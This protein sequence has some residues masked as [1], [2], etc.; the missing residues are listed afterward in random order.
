MATYAETNDCRRRIIL[1]HFGDVGE[2][3]ADD[4]CDNC[5]AKK[6]SPG[7]SQ[8]NGRLSSEER[9][10]LVI[11]DCIRRLKNKIGR[12]KL[13]KILSGSQARDILEF[14]YDRNIYYGRF[15]GVRQ[16]E[17]EAML[18][19]LVKKGYIKTIGGR[20]PVLTLTPKGETA[21][22]T[23]EKIGLELPAAGN[24]SMRNKKKPGSTLEFTAEL[25]ARG[26]NSEQIAS[27]RNLAISTINYHLSQLIESG[28]IAIEQVV[29]D[30]IRE[31]VEDA[32]REIGSD[33]RLSAIKAILPEEISY[34]EIHFV[35]A[36]LRYHSNTTDINSSDIVE[37][38]LSKSHPRELK[39]SWQHGWSLGFH[40]AFSG[41]SWARS[42]IGEM[43]YRLKY[44]GDTTVMKGLVAEII[45][46][47][48]A[49]PEL[50]RADYIVPVPPSE[51]RSNDHVQ[52]LCEAVGKRIMIPVKTFLKKSRQTK[53]QKEMK[54]LAQKKS[55]V[56]RAFSLPANI[57]GDRI[58]LVDDLFDSGATLEEATQLLY[59]RGAEEINVLTLTRTIHSDA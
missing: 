39:G 57:K 54:T 37:N 18:G 59:R 38:F 36:A 4:C 42:D 20:L 49:Y 47:L 1:H 9:A 45:E 25:F 19:Q 46:L 10:V 16:K 7:I 53:P 44:N 33:K 21:V 34:D 29:R 26:M 6:A 5:S 50:K 41:S 31:K 23:K 11:L 40:S 28:I 32:V 13:V 27:E 58:L 8:G 14:H 17:I 43:A 15:I 12:R 51:K 3:K 30:D 2:V 22:Q 55:N 35:V 48:H 24:S 56:Q 52:I